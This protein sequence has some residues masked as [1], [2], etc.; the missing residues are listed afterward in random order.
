MSITTLFKGTK[1]YYWEVKFAI[2]HLSWWKLI[3]LIEPTSKH[4]EFSIFSTLT[5]YLKVV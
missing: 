1:Y 4:W 5:G 2:F 3:T